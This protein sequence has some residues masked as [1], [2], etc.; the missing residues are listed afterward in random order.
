MQDLKYEDN[1]NTYN[2]NNNNLYCV[3]D[4]KS[5]K[6][7]KGNNCEKMRAQSLRNSKS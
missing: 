1:C 7:L 6:K 4:T 2:N 3:L 5:V